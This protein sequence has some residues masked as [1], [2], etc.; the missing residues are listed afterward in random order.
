[1]VADEFD[2]SVTVLCS[3]S[4][5]QTV[6]MARGVAIWLLR[7][8]LGLSYHAIGTWFGNRDHT[9]ILH[10]FQK[11]DAKISSDSDETD[12]KTSVSSL[13]RVLQHR[14]NDLFAGQMTLIP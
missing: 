5:K 7:T 8:M 14:L 1:M 4:R 10:A 11:Y 9:T 6:V 13:V 12:S 2:L 3:D